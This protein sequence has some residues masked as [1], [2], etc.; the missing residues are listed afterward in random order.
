VDLVDEL[1][2]QTAAAE[3]GAAEA[4]VYR[5]GEVVAA[6]GS[7]LVVR[8]DGVDVAWPAVRRLAG[9]TP[10]VGQ[11]VACLRSGHRYVIIGAIA[12]SP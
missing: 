11:A 6:T 7:A 4:V 5:Y 3:H 12:E 9:Y 1:V 10:V 8:V 2:R